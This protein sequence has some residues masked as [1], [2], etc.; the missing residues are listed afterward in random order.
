MVDKYYTSNTIN[1][2]FI[3]YDTKIKQFIDDNSNNDEPIAIVDN[4]HNLSSLTDVNFAYCK[5][6]YTDNTDV[7]NPIIYSKGLY[8]YDSVNSKWNILPLHA[9]VDLSEIEEA[10]ESLSSNKVD[11]DELDE[12][13]DKDTYMSEINEGNVKSADVANKIKGTELAKPYQFFGLDGTGEAKFQY[14]PIQGDGQVTQGNFEQRKIIDAKANNIYEIGS[15]NELDECKIFVQAYTEI[16]GQQNI[17]GT[18]KEFNNIHKNSFYCNNNVEFSE[19]GCFIKTIYPLEVSSYNNLYKTN[20][21][22]K[23]DYINK[24]FLLIQKG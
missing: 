14:L 18:I 16:E 23:N 21:I 8:F 13:L 20:T 19:E 12:Y 10:L 5:N 6:E 1:N 3:S 7:N 2:M 11:R 17:V 4:Y 24:K 9:T 15:L 22:N